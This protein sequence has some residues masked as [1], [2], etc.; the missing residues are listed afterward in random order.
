LL[1]GMD[2]FGPSAGGK[3][4]APAPGPVDTVA[5]SQADGAP[6]RQ[7]RTPVKAEPPPPP[8]PLPAVALYSSPWPLS[9]PPFPPPHPSLH[10]LQSLVPSSGF[11]ASPV[12]TAPQQTPPT[13]PPQYTP[14]SS[15]P[16]RDRPRPPLRAVPSRSSSLRRQPQ[17]SPAA[18][19]ARP[20]A[21]MGLQTATR[22]GCSTP[23]TRPSLASRPAHTCPALGPCGTFLQEGPERRHGASGPPLQLQD[24]RESERRVSCFLELP[25]ALLGGLQHA[26]ASFPTVPMTP[27]PG[28]ARKSP[29]RPRPNGS[30]ST[31]PSGWR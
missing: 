24:V 12:S 30:P 21:S 15:N 14:R 26:P 25:P 22:M 28:T 7:P 20:R 13:P 5:L 18:P 6:S 1:G 16:S 8:P 11:G 3:D 27:R 9:P 29:T 31:S 17:P 19:P 10:W 4:G 2:P 23:R